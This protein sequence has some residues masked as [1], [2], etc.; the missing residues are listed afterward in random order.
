LFCADHGEARRL[1]AFARMYRLKLEGN[2]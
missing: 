1:K 2:L